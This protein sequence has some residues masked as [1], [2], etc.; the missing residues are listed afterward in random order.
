MP[1][2]V[3]PYTNFHELNLDTI[4]QYLTEI[5]EKAGNID[6]SIEQAAAYASA[7]DA[8]ARS[9]ANHEAGAEA[10]KN[11]CQR[12]ASDLM[13]N[14]VPLQNQVN[15]NSARIDEFTHLAEGSTTGDAELIDIRVSYTGETYDTAGDSVRNQVSDRAADM[16]EKIEKLDSGQ[17]LLEWTWGNISP[18]GSINYAYDPRVRIVN[19]TYIK[20]TNETILN[21]ANG[22]GFIIATYDDSY[23]LIERTLYAGGGPIFIPANTYF[24]A[25]IYHGSIIPDSVYDFAD[26]LTYESNINKQINALKE[27]HKNIV[28]LEVGTGK[29]YA[30]FTAAFAACTDPANND[31]II[32]YYGNGNEYI[33]NNEP[34]FNENLATP[35]GLKKIIGVGDRDKNILVDSSTHIPYGQ[36]SVFYIKYGCSIENL[37]FKGNGKYNIHID[38]LTNANTDLTINNCKFIHASGGSGCIGIGIHANEI[39]RITQCYFEQSTDAAIRIHNWDN[40][41][42]SKYQ[43]LYVDGCY[44]VAAAMN[45]SIHLYTTNRFN[46]ANYEYA[47]AFITNNELN[48]LPIIMSEEDHTT[49]GTGNVWRITGNNNSRSDVYIRHHDNANYSSM[50]N[51]FLPAAHINEQI[52]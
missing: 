26:K 3:F 1:F 29:P 7:S 41:I 46:F 51:M 5:K 35:A 11:T 16:N 50:V 4:I 15:V 28:N 14:Y 48:N 17:R 37:V 40:E 43:H 34:G 33:V 10:Y 39:I 19:T 13:I 27:Y 21:R 12:I 22:F 42:D 36:E 23:N 45:Y 9:A 47:N 24:R 8:A 44:F 31:Y 49:Y 38:D 6:D 2:E 25:C 20:F 32:Y 30:T 52:I 18:D